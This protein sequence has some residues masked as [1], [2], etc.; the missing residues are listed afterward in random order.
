[1]VLLG[2]PS[3]AQRAAV[4]EEAAAVLAALEDPALA[5]LTD[6]ARPALLRARASVLAAAANDEA[7]E[8]ASLGQAAAGAVEGRGLMD[9]AADFRRRLDAAAGLLIAGRAGD[10]S[11]G[12]QGW[13]EGWAALLALLGERRDLAPRP[14]DA[15]EA[16]LLALRYAPDA[17]SWQAARE[18][19]GAVLREVGLAAAPAWRGLTGE[20]SAA[21]RLLPPAE[22]LAPLAALDADAGL[23]PNPEVR[24]RWV[25]GKLALAVT[26]SVDA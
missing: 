12:D 23:M 26:D 8:R 7:G 13:A 1:T 18:R 6:D 25:L 14:E 21:N 20:A 5:G 11:S 9:A 22:R 17:A 24:R 10:S 3:E 2:L 4:L 16:A 15:G 19:A